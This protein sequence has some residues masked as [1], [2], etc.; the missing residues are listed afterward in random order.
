MLGK[1]LKYEL[2]SMAHYFVP[3][4]AATL[5][6]SVLIPLYGNVFG[7]NSYWISGLLIFVEA[8]LIIA[9]TV[10][11]LV[12]TIQRFYKNLL[13]QEGY[14][15]FTLP[16]NTHH[17][18]LSKLL[19]AMLWNTGALLIVALSVIII[20]AGSGNI[21]QIFIALWR[22]FNDTFAT[23]SLNPFLMLFEWTVIGIINLASNILLLYLAMSIGQ[24]ANEHKFLASFGAYL[25]LEVILSIITAIIGVIITNLPEAWSNGFQIWYAA[26][27]PAAAMHLATLGLALISMVCSVLYYFITHWLL[28]HRL[29]LT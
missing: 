27:S 4:F 14:L 3:L 28:K 23:A 18:I 8:V 12:I 21:S 1:L 16:V 24:L 20:M 25:G 19:A 15:M 26:L 29:N 11:A 7:N 2:K 13:G 9:L 22:L 6:F 10:M 17:N 5:L